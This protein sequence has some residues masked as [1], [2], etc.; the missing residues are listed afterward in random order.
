METPVAQITSLLGE[1]DRGTFRH[2]WRVSRLAVAIAVRLDAPPAQCEAAGLAGLLHDVG[3]LTVP[4]ALI[5]KPDALTEAETRIME[6]HAARGARIVGTFVPPAITHVVAHHH[7]RVD[8]SPTLP[9]MTRLV[10]VADTY[11]A[12]VS[13][14]PYRPGRT[15]EAAAR[16]LRRVA[17]T[18]LDGDMVEALIA[19]LGIPRRQLVDAGR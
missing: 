16:E 18:Q 12:L 19:T 3:K 1:H 6:A 14:R 9:W 5:T 8:A 10:S 2:S 7:D 4:T 17:G 13:D 11:D 15:L